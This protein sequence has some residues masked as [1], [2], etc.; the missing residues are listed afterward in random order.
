MAPERLSDRIHE[1]L[2]TSESQP[3]SS[4]E[5]G[6]SVLLSL[7]EDREGLTRA[8]RHSP[9][10]HFLISLRSSAS[11]RTQA[12]QLRRLA[13]YL[14]A[15]DW[16]EV[17]WTTLGY[18]GCN[19]VLAR[20]SADEPSAATYNAAR[21]A[22]RGVMKQAFLLQQLDHETWMRIQAIPGERHSASKAPAGRFLSDVEIREIFQNC[23]NGTNLGCRDAAIIAVLLFG[24]L[25]RSE[26]ASLELKD[27]RLG[28]SLEVVGKGRKF[29]RV[30]MIP[31]LTKRLESWYLARGIESGP[32]FRRISRKDRVLSPGISSQT[33]YKVVKRRAESMSC[34]PHDARRT[35]VSRLL[36]ASHDLS[37]ARRLAGHESTETTIRYDRREEI[38][39]QE[40]M[41]ELA[42]YEAN[43]HKRSGQDGQS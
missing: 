25:R 40:A 38:A 2:V 34:S 32:F 27:L 6:Y 3:T 15:S 24:G 5:L 30:P 9:A 14:G 26:A 35:F 1:L 11:R 41:A 19:A 43:S 37:A 13:R 33:I 22:L 4:L 20:L 18:A 10:A 31:Q 8:L 17:D 36:A 12:A 7:P 28:E 21:S 42:R 23:E 16:H 29:R 39:D